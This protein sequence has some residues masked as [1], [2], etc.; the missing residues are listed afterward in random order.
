M[1]LETQGATKIRSYSE[2][3]TKQIDWLWYPYIAYGKVTVIQGGPG[4]GKT[5]FALNIAAL[6]S[7]GGGHSE[8][9]CESREPQNIIYQSAENGFA[10]TIK[11]RL[12]S[13]GA[14]CSRI[15]FISDKYYPLTLDDERLEAA[16]RKCGAKLLVL[17]S[18]ESFIGAD[19]DL[20]VLLKQLGRIAEGAD[21]AVVVISTNN[22]TD[23]ARNVI[24]VSR[25]R[26]NP[27]IRVISQP[28]N[29]L[30]PEGCPV[31]FELSETE[32]FRWIGS[33]D[34]WKLVQ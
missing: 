16:I 25:L 28:K 29:T 17:D 26:G 5:T 20:R 34:N 4:V 15:S 30:A 11:P 9:A 6:L 7:K 18:L 12:Q 32:G 24:Q 19:A 1:S 22:I 10:D 14:D 2:I 33:Y 13:A 31:A 3:S 8:C 21:C 27:E 23:V